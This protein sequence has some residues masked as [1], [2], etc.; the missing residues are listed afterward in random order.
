MKRLIRIYLLSCLGFLLFGCGISNYD[1]GQEFLAQEE[2]KAA[3]DYFTAA[4]EENVGADEAHRELGI[5]Y[6]RGRFFPQA[7]THLQ[8][9]SDTLKDERTA[10]YHGMALEQNRKYEQAIDAYEEF[11]AL[12]DSPE[13]GY[14]IK[15]RLAHLRNQHLI[16]SA[17]QAVQAADQI[18]L[19]TIPEDK[20]AVYY[21]ELLPGRDDLVPL[22]K[23]ITAL[24]ISDLEKVRG[25]SVVPR[26]QLQRMLDQMRLQQDSVFNQETKNRVGRL[27]GVANVCAGTIE[28][29]A[30][31]DLRLSATVVKVRAGDIEAA[32]VQQGAESDF[33]DLQKSMSFDILDALGVRP[34]ER[35][36]RVLNRRATESL[37]ALIAY[38]RGLAANDKSDFVAAEQYFKLSLKEDPTF[39]LALRELDYVRLLAEA[40]EQNLTQIE[41]LAMESAKAKTARQQRLNRMNQALSRQFI[42]PTAADSPREGDIDPPKSEIQVVV[43]N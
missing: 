14:Q 20:V 26:L 42:P 8:I 19:T 32:S 36:K 40:Q 43:K 38:G 37:S 23:A 28:G 10:L 12:N 18:D 5:T 6:Y 1:R 34:T 33:F 27:L 24:V 4:T 21:F 13:I 7:V 11:S 22:Q 39:Q 3:A 41:E 9:A 17:K 25:I 31:L 16:Q 35:Q 15:A 30:D 29:L 2:L